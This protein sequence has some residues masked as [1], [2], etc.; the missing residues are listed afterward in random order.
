MQENEATT[1]TKEYAQREGEPYYPVPNSNNQ[2]I[3]NQYKNEADKLKNVIFC[4]RLAEY[5]Y[6]N[7][8][9]VVGKIINLFE[10][11]GNEYIINFSYGL[12]FT[13]Y[14]WAK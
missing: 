4:G 11:K 10:K 14:W 12:S 5:K 6:Y 13:R 2:K 3:Y 8:D 1:I 9:Q 7:M